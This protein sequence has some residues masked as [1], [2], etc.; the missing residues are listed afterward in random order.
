[1]A[2]PSPPSPDCEAISPVTD[3]SASM[4][5]ATTVRR[6]KTVTA[7]ASALMALDVFISTS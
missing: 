6:K 1:V 4:A 2:P 3:T 5:C 7:K